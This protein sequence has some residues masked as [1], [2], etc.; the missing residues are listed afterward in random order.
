MRYLITFCLI[1]SFLSCKEQVIKP[2]TEATIQRYYGITYRRSGYFKEA[3]EAYQ[4][5]KVQQ[6][7]IST[8]YQGI[9]TI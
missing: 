9:L 2:I 7:L 8:E 4:K 3:L 1:I 5:T 6:C